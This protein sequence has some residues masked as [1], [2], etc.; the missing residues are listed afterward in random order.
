MCKDPSDYNRVL[1]A[2]Q[3]L[4][5]YQTKFHIVVMI[6]VGYNLIDILNSECYA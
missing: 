2:S 4:F 5:Q 3:N 6:K 1:S